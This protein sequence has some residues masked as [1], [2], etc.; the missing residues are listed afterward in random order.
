M[1][2]KEKTKKYKSINTGE[3]ALPICISH[4][5]NNIM[6]DIEQN[7]YIDFTSG[8]GVTNAGWQRIE[9]INAIKNQL[10]KL[11][12]SSPWFPTNEA[13]ELSELLLSIMPEN[14][15]MCSRSTGGAESN[16]TI[17]K[18][19]YAL[20]GKKDVLSLARSYHGGSKFT[21]NMS[22][23]ESFRLPKLPSK[24]QYHKAPSPYCYRCPFGKL[25]DSCNM[26]CGLAVEDIIKNNPDI[27]IF[28]LEPV[29]GSGGV[30]IPPQKYFNIVQEICR[31][32]NVTFV[33]DEVITGFGRLGML[34]GMDM[35]NVVP[36]A[37]SFGKG[38]GGGFIPIGASVLSKD[39]AEVFSKYE[40]VSAT[41]AWTPLAC[42]AA[43]SN[44]ELIIKEDLALKSKD[45]GFYLMEQLQFLFN[46]YIPEQLG[47]VRGKGLLIGVELV[48]NQLSKKPAI[49]LIKTLTFSLIRNGLMVC[50]SWDFQVLIFM[51][52]LNI[53]NSDIDK[54]LDIVESQLQFIS[55]TRNQ[56]ILR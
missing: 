52:P 24:N 16:E 6:Y 38:M 53:S 43:K 17:L 11:I 3:V 39:L 51:P 13:I 37:V 41:F 48:E 55:Q 40:D 33:F 45:K 28:Y 30:I 22:D 54:A 1:N 12:Y 32:H 50:T 14:S 7:S 2:N 31:T 42:V 27:G 36:D 49:R 9:V 8:F 23:V 15:F 29:I 19:S 47:E 20:N 10:D 4:I 21:V 44:I 46:K 5:E 26:E 18:A 34:T 25:H 35:F 56:N